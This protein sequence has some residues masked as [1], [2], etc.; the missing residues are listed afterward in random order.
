MNLFD[1]TGKVVF[2]TGGTR[3]IGLAIALG[4]KE[5]GARVW[6]HGSKEES[7]AK[8]A[9]EHG[10]S[11]VF[12][13]LK[14]TEKLDE[15]LVPL[16][17]KEEKL[18]VL[19]NNAGFE[20]HCEMK[21]VGEAEMDAIYNVNTKSPVFIIQKVLPMIRKAG[22]GS[23][24]NVTSIH[25]KVPVRTN[26]SY[27]MSK[28]S[29]S[30]YTKVAAL[31]LAKENIRVNNLAPGAI[32][33]DMNRE[34]VE[35]MDFDQWIPME[36]VGRSEELAGPAVFLASDASSYITGATLYVDGG[37]SENLLRY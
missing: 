36:R 22:G 19:V 3:G 21:D 15:M 6:I 20:T 9:K 1:L 4:M 37:Y 32:L 14:E 2:V 24:I 28:A 30:M 29:L 31:E 11:Y 12:G 7:T 26:G 10:F 13:N 18:D 8:V 25:Q 16:L 17:E 34:I 35:A 23:I 5:A 33:T 27:C